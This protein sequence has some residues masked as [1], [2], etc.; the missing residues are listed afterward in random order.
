ME[1]KQSRSELS[2]IQT[3]VIQKNFETDD[4]NEEGRYRIKLFDLPSQVSSPPPDVLPTMM[5]FN[6]RIQCP[7]LPAIH[8]ERG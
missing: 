8:G 7:C 2:D 4:I 5:T 3:G 1:P 6:R